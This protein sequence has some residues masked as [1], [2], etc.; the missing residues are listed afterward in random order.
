M[1]MNEPGTEEQKATSVLGAL[2]CLAA[3]APN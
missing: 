2:F 3:A 1:E